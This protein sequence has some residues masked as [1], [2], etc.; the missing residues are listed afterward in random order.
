MEELV[1]EIDKSR[2]EAS[3]VNELVYLRAEHRVA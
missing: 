2:N 1:R 3:K